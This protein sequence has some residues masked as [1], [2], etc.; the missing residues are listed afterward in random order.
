MDNT[1]VAI[2]LIDRELNCYIIL[3]P[4][5]VILLLSLPQKWWNKGNSYYCKMSV[6]VNCFLKSVFIQIVNVL[7]ISECKHTRKSGW[8]LILLL[9]C[10]IKIDIIFCKQQLLH[11]GNL[12]LI[13]NL[14]RTCPTFQQDLRQ[15]QYGLCV[16]KPCEAKLP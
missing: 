4:S 2:L 3:M 10:T 1:A 8:E 13:N 11:K 5:N 15:Q 12:F 6:H 16:E 7:A 14:K 9:L